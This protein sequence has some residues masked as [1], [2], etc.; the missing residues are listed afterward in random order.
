M[1]ELAPFLRHR[2]EALLQPWTGGVVTEL[3]QGDGTGNTRR[4][5]IVGLV[6][7]LLGTLDRGAVPTTILSGPE[8]GEPAGGVGAD[9]AT[10][11]QD[12]GRLHRLVAELAQEAVQPS[13]VLEE[14]GESESEPA[15]WLSLV[16]AREDGGWDRAAVEGGDQ[17][18]HEADNGLTSDVLCPISSDQ[19]RDDAPGPALNERLE[20]VPQKGGE[21]THGRHLYQRDVFG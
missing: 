13:V 5:G 16:G 3:A 6:Q 1:S 14:R 20:P 11:L 17:R 15:D 19:L 10:R 18:M 2:L 8:P 12:H 7:A 4:E 21:L 9:L